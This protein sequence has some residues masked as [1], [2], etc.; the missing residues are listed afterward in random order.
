MRGGG[1]VK[2]GQAREVPVS[3][4]RRLP[5]PSDS[6]SSNSRQFNWA[7]R[8]PYYPD[9]GNQLGCGVCGAFAVVGAMEIMYSHVEKEAIHLSKQQL[10]DCDDRVN[11]DD[12]GVK[13]R[14]VFQY[15][16]RNYLATEDRYPYRGTQG[17]QDCNRRAVKAGVARILSY[18]RVRG[19]EEIKEALRDGP[20]PASVIGSYL[21]G[22]EDGIIT[23]CPN[24]E[25]DHHVTIVGYGVGYVD[26]E[27]TPYYYIRN[28]WGT[29]Y[30]L[31][32]H[33]KI[34]RGTCNIEKTAYSITIERRTRGGFSCFGGQ[35]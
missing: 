6:A 32:G 9:A 27:E 16:K 22:Y 11:C 13:L 1:P 5:T 15:L 26:G 18:R 4:N 20:L 34:K 30:G 23:N 25:T 2:P 24:T 31:G 19:E 3:L 28:S 35:C 29:G 14:P 17:D 10:V 21:E 7:Y 8:N 33:A 12:E